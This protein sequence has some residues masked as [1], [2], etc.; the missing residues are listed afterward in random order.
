LKQEATIA[1]DILQSFKMF[2]KII[3]IATAGKISYPLKTLNLLQMWHCDCC[4]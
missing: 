3:A 2:V 1:T 4:N